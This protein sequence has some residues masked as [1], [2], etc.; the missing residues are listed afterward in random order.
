ML[1]SIFQGLV[2]LGKCK[3]KIQQKMKT[4]DDKLKTLLNDM[5]KSSYDKVGGKSTLQ[6]EL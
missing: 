4:A 1:Y 6:F 2:N 3:E 5:S